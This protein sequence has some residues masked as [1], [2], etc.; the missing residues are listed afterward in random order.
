MHRE[1][2]RAFIIGGGPSVSNT[3]L[4]CLEGAGFTVIGVNNAY[5]L[6]GFVNYCWFGDYKWWQTNETGLKA[7]SGYT[8]HCNEHSDLRSITMLRGFARS[9]DK[10]AGIET[11][12]LMVAWNASSG[13]SAVN[14]AYHLG[15]KEIVL[16]GFDMQ[17]VN[18]RK[19]WHKDHPPPEGFDKHGNGYA[20]AEDYLDDLYARFRKPFK[21]VKEDAG[22][23]GIEII[24]CTPG[25]ALTEFPVVSLPEY[26]RAVS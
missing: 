7:Y 5:K 21:A 14:F 12:P 24:N 9:R 3:D 15:A 10:T 6:G 20:T 11:N 1:S 13:G 25:S 23:L 2:K 18:S 4:S 26:I 16:I 17:T 19:N 8:A 22:S